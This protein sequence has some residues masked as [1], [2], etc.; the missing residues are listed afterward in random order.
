MILLLSPLALFFSLSCTIHN[1]HSVYTE[2]RG[3]L[4]VSY[5]Q[6]IKL[7]TVW[8]IVPQFDLRGIRERS[9]MSVSKVC[10]ESGLHVCALW[11][12]FY[13]EFVS[14]W[15]GGWAS[16]Q[17]VFAVV[18]EQPQTHYKMIKIWISYSKFLVRVNRLPG[19]F[20][21]SIRMFIVSFTCE[22]ET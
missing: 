3:L 11:H 14:F 7:L 2:L 13:W 10:W 18:V 21:C 8:L 12:A 16:C 20:I 17:F 6:T 5:S 22:R 1:L 9:A 15:M 19:W 4:S